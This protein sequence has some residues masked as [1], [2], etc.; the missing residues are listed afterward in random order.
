LSWRILPSSNRS[1]A[2]SEQSASSAS[3]DHLRPQRAAEA[4][5]ARIVSALFKL[6]TEPKFSEKLKD[7]VSHNVDLKGKRCSRALGPAG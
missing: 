1:T 6:S 5:V 3:G 2:N 4:R 7:V